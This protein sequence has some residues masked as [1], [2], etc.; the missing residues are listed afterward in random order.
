MIF[1]HLI[2]SYLILIYFNK[3]Q[4]QLDTTMMWLKCNISVN[5]LRTVIEVVY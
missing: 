1:E 5:I 3:K 2:F 4:Y